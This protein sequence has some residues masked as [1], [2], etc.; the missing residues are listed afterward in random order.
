MDQ[1][2]DS[3]PFLQFLRH[4]FQ[5]QATADGEQSAVPPSG[6]NVSHASSGVNA[7]QSPDARMANAAYDDMPGLQDV[8][9]S[10]SEGESES[11]RDANE[12][13]MQAIDGSSTARPVILRNL[14]LQGPV[15]HMQLSRYKPETEGHR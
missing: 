13:T 8:S 9:D 10:E 5:T 12:V 15:R 1:N 7:R 2:P 11:V 3:H 6:A 14:L 4:A